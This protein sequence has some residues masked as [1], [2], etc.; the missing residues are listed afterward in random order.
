MPRLT[1]PRGF[2][3]VELL[4]VIGIIAV[5]V[6]LL[7][8]TLGK[9]R[10]SAAQVKSA[11]NCRQLLLG[12]AM[13]HQDNHGSVLFGHTPASVAGTV[14]DPVSMQSFGYPVSDRYP[15][16][17]VRYVAGVWPI[18]HG[19]ERTPPYPTA[20][21]PASAAFLKAYTLSLSPTFGINSVYVGGDADDAGYNAHGS[22][23]VGAHVVFKATEVRRP[24]ELIVFADSRATNV[25]GMVAS[26]YHLV[27]PPRANGLNWTVVGGQARATST[28][29]IVGLPR[30]WFG[31]SV[32]V[33]F[34][35]GHVEAVPPSRLTDM[36]LWANRATGPNYDDVQ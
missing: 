27:T 22:P 36:W 10:Q 29:Q 26:G 20:A 31:P 6:A 7:L 9:A 8:P 25:P 30:G 4:V 3:L 12:Y 13:Y 17:L 35:D 2:T 33:G 15:W 32:V 28:V 34:F 11:S 14:Y 24:S 1:S 16:R 21:D 19:H 18:V 5:L 23:N